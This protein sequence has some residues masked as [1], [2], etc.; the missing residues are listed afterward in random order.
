MS[1]FDC[2]RV[3]GPEMDIH[4]GGTDLIFPHHE[5][6]EAQSCAYHGGESWVRYWIHTGM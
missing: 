1:H 5:N 2:S 6:E 3:F 4:S